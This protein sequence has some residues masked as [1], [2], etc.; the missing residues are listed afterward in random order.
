MLRCLICNALVMPDDPYCEV[1]GEPQTMQVYQYDP[2]SDDD[3]YLLMTDS[4][5][6]LFLQFMEDGL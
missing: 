3:N 2:V 5:F 6:A 1:C 4:E